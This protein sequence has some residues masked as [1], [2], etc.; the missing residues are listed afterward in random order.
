MKDEEEER[1]IWKEPKP[2]NNY[3]TG[4]CTGSNFNGRGTWGAIRNRIM[5]DHIHI[6][7]N[8]M[9]N[10]MRRE[11]MFLIWRRINLHTD[12]RTTWEKSQG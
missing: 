3:N 1:K 2:R 8:N 7:K 5:L 4:L 12:P 9:Y 10:V 11:T 6:E